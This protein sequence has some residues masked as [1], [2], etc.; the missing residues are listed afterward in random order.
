MA[1]N[2]EG[3]GVATFRDYAPEQVVEA[4]IV[5]V[6]VVATPVED[7]AVAEKPAPRAVIKKEN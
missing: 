6:P 7:Q 1:S 4:S 5:D 2:N 3:I